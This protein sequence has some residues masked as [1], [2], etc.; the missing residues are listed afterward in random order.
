[1]IFHPV[2]G[3]EHALASQAVTNAEG[4]FQLATHVGGGKFKAG[5]VPGQYA[6]AI[7]KL[8]TAAIS[9]TLAPPKNLLPKKL[10]DPAT[11]G[12]SADVTVGKDNNFPFALDA[13]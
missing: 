6:V 5:I 12:L 4:Q 9:G 11:S 10:G 7:T 8:D 2:D 13:N 3:A 1:M